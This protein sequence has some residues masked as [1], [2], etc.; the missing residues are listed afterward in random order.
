M[1]PIPLGNLLEQA[2]YNS[3]NRT[4]YIYNYRAGIITPESVIPALGVVGF[5]E[6]GDFNSNTSHTLSLSIVIRIQPG[7]YANDVLPFKDKLELELITIQGLEAAS[8]RYRCIPLVVTQPKVAGGSTV[9][10]NLTALDAQNFVEVEL[11]LLELAYEPMMNTYVNEGYLISKVDDAL[12][13]AMQEYCSALPLEGN[14]KFEDVL[15]EYPVTNDRVYDHITI[16]PGLTI[17]NVPAF[18]QNEYGVY[19]FGL[20]AFFIGNKWYIYSLMDGDK[21]DQAENTLDILRV[22]EDAIPTL[23]HTYYRNE[24]AVTLIA[25]G[26]SNHQ[27]VSDIEQREKG[28]GTQVMHADALT[29]E[30][31]NHYNNGRSVASRGDSM[32]EFRT[33]E[34]GTGE[35]NDKVVF[36]GNV[37]DNVCK[38]LSESRARSGEIISLNWERA[39]P[40]LLRPGMA[41]KYFYMDENQILYSRKGVLLAYRADA[42]PNGVKPVIDFYRSA[43]LV[44]FLNAE[45]TKE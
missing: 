36:S 44:I 15:I 14:S 24:G 27:D 7:V 22:P 26:G 43:G 12:H 37:T 6:F 16:P 20:G 40:G 35:V 13:S 1:L 21:Y 42:I 19:A 18:M 32:I 5:S 31:G 9:S 39:D 2:K 4:S 10:S 8:R 3:S 29:G 11:Q 25:T 30:T 28:T 34:R 23:E 41:I 33:V 38:L 45:I 17:P